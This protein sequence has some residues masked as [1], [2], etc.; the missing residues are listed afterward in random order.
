MT[1]I[2]SVRLANVT[3]MDLIGP[4]QVLRRLPGATAHLDFVREAGGEVAQRSQLVLGYDP[5]P[6]F[7]G[8][9]PVSRP[10]PSPPSCA[11]STNLTSPSS[12]GG[13]AP[14]R[15]DI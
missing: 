9:S 1:D 12:P 5:H 6:P 4:L 13:S 8:G 3:Q 10:R 11:T 2:G 7:H 15:P 14:L